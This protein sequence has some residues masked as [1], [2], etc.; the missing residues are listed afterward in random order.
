MTLDCSIEHPLQCIQLSSDRF[1][2]CHGWWSTNQSRVCII[3]TSGH[4]IQFYGGRRGP[5]IGQMM[6]PSKMAVDKHGHVMVAD[7]HNSRV[8]LL[9]PTL[10]H[11]GYI[12]IPG[13][14]LKGPRALH[15][16]ELNHRLYI[17]ERDGRIS[18]LGAE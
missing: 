8:E 5:N 1:V 6:T 11:L 7:W 9:S 10:T 18:V 15:L 16:D 2:V 13:Y 14:E 12:Q 4:I 17:G 3:D